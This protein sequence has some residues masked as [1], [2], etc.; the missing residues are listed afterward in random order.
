[1]TQSQNAALRESAFR[2]FVG[3]QMLGMG[4]TDDV[5]TV[6]KGGLEDKEN[7]HVGLFHLSCLSIV[8]TYV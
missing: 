4:Q 5:L 6:L 1:M 2:L 3:T 8:V 7:V